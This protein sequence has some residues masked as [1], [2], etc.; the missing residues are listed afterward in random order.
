MTI[1]KASNISSLHLFTRHFMLAATSMTE[2]SA[3]PWEFRTSTLPGNQIQ[4]ANMS[5]WPRVCLIEKMQKD[6]SKKL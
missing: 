1:A 3:T 5:K 4:S 6:M 2:P